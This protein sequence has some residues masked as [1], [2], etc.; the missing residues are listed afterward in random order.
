MKKNKLFLSIS[1][2]IC[3]ICIAITLG[4][5]FS[6]PKHKHELGEARVYHVSQDSIYYT[7][8]CDDG[9]AENFSTSATSFAASVPR[10]ISRSRFRSSAA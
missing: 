6:Q 9:H 1:M 7:R 10:S 5:A 4:I 8:Q 3:V 2:A